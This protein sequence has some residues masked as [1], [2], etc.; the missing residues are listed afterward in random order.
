MKGELRSLPEVRQVD[1]DGAFYFFVDA[2]RYGSSV[3]LARRLLDK[4]R[5][6]TIPG[7]AFGQNA[8]GWLRLSFACAEDPLREGLRRIRDEL[9][10]GN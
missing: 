3:E 8:A 2:S 6:I 5:V 10:A 7:E 9:Q 4:Q 1:P